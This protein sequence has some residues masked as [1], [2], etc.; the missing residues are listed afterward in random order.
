MTTI[1]IEAIRPEAA[2]PLRQRILRPSQTVA[3]QRYTFDHDPLTFH[4]GAYRDDEL[5]GIA[6]VTPEEQGELPYS[7][8]WRLRGMAVEP[9]LQGQGIGR[10][11]LERCHAEIIAHGG[12]VVWCHGR[13]SAG[14]FY[15]ALGYRPFG[16]EFLS[17]ITGPHYVF[18]RV[19]S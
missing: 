16:A 13:T 2:L 18:Y 1:R 11:L 8:G 14:A 10:R 12:Q 6:T 4:A 9:A 7:P 3:E 5:I 17:P 15:R 19:L